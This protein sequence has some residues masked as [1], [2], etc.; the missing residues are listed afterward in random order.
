MTQIYKNSAYHYVL[1][2]QQKARLTPIPTGSTPVQL[3]LVPG[4]WGATINP[5]PNGCHSSIFS[6]IPF[7]PLLRRSSVL[8]HCIVQLHSVTQRV[9]AHFSW[10]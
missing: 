9:Q 6:K 3:D 2:E 10:S 8:L 5:I 1:C 7:P 4:V